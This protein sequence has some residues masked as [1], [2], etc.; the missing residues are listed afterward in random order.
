MCAYRERE[1]GREAIFPYLQSFNPILCV[2]FQQFIFKSAAFITS[3]NT[4][5]Q[6]GETRR[7]KSE[8]V[9]FFS[10][11]FSSVNK[12]VLERTE[13]GGGRGKNVSGFL[14]TARLIPMCLWSGGER[15]RREE[16]REHWCFNRPEGYVAHSKRNVH[17][18]SFLSNQ[19]QKKKAV[20]PRL[21]ILNLKTKIPTWCSITRRR[22][23]CQ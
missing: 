7:E 10:P 14:C 21:K 22:R 11:S 17:F 12:V 1:R 3:P 13:R 23:N 9:L 15:E 18:S 6:G 16:K 8:W 5:E 20:I 4:S 19:I 2:A